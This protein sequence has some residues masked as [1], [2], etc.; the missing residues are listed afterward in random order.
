M[1]LTRVEYDRL[2]RKRRKCRSG[3]SCDSPGRQRPQ[4]ASAP[5]VASGPE[6]SAFLHPTSRLPAS[7]FQTPINVGKYTQRLADLSNEIAGVQL[8]LAQYQTRVAGGSHEGLG[9]FIEQG[10]TIVAGLSSLHDRTSQQ[11]TMHQHLNIRDL[12]L[13]YQHAVNHVNNLGGTHPA[14]HPRNPATYT[15]RTALVEALTDKSHYGFEPLDILQYYHQ[16]QNPTPPPP[17][18]PTP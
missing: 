14:S 5:P 2:V 12:Q 9:H 18:A 1:A 16:L 10:N 13:L 4:G 7:M 11:R 8:D 3:G 17:P 15:S 6:V